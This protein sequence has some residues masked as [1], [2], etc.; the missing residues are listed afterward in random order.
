MIQIFRNSIGDINVV[1][2]GVWNPRLESAGD[3][4]DH[5]MVVD[6]EGKVTDEINFDS[7]PDAE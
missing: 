7:F 6:E 1:N 5:Q 2:Y 3:G 4:Y